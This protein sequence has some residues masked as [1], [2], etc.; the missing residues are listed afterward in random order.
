MLFLNVAS[1]GATLKFMVKDC[2]PATGQPDSDEGYDDEYIL[3]DL[4]VT[5]ADQIQMNKTTNF[6]AAWDAAANEGKCSVFL[7]LVGSFRNCTHCWACS[8]DL[9]SE[10][11]Q[12]SACDRYEIKS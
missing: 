2:D 8:L 12:K 1:F 7:K 4:E 9:E 11:A 5:V 10:F 6:S 3:E